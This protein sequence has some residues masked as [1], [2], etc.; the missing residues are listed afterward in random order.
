MKHIKTI[1]LVNGIILM[2]F[3]TNAQVQLDKMKSVFIYNFAKNTEWP[4]NYKTGNFVIGILG[5]C[6][7]AKEL[8][9][10]EG[11]RSIGSQTIKIKVYSTPTEIGRC[12]ILYIPQNSS[13]MFTQALSKV[14]STLV[15]TDKP[16]LVNS[17]AGISFVIQGS[18]LRFK[19]N[20]TNIEKRKLEVS[21]AL[22]DLSL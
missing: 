17:G 21:K 12:H 7:V 11:V 13:K 15:V 16:D 5:D 1:L 20:N 9:K 19:L 3:I 6:G 18:K 10:I 22:E 4:S 14:G 2:S 8:K